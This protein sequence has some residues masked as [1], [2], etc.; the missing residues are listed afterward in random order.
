MLTVKTYWKARRSLCFGK[1]VE[2]LD[3]AC[4]KS[5][6]VRKPLP[7]GKKRKFH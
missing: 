6:K 7:C 1:P 5:S 4:S 3:A 2:T